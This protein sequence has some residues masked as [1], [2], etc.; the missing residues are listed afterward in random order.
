VLL[1][2]IVLDG[3]PAP[4][5]KRHNPQF[6]VHVCCGQTAVWIKMPH[7]TQAGLGPGDIVL[8]GDPAAPFIKRGHSTRNFG[9]HGVAKR[10]HGSRCH[11]VLRSASAQA[12]LCYMRTQLPPK[13]GTPAASFRPMSVVAKRLVGPK[14]HLTGGRRRLSRHCVTWGPS[15]H[16][17]GTSPPQFSADL[18]WPNGWMDEDATWHIGRP[19]PRRHCVKWGSSSPRKGHSTAPPLF[20][21]CLLWRSGWM[22]QDAT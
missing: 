14:C 8:D 11:L 1:T 4:S 16:Q 2:Y 12:T 7:G 15:S 5:Q 13:R 21:P 17:R 3:D 22:Y 10:L 19:W 18:V 6:S 9:L 20:G